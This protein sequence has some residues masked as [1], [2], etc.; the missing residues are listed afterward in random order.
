MTEDERR[1]DDEPDDHGERTIAGDFARVSATFSD[2]IDGVP[3]DGWD[4]PAP[5]D[6]WVARD[7][8]DHLVG[9]VPSVLAAAGLDCRVDADDSPA[10]RWSSLSSTIEQALA[11]PAIATREFDAGPPGRMTVEVA[12]ARLVTGDVLVHTWDLAAA[13]GQ[14]VVLDPGVAH[15]MLVGMEPMD[16]LLRSSGHFGPRVD[17]PAGADD[18]TRLLAFTGRDVTAWD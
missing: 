10:Q 2:V 9:W 18:T 6:G 17:A 12:V 3:A 15:D 7:V 14:R 13:T 11:D 16:E 5:C 4:R 1:H 8:V